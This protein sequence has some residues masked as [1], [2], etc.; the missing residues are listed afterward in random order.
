MKAATTN[1][2]MAFKTRREEELEAAEGGGDDSVDAGAGL[3]RGAVQRMQDMEARAAQ[4]K[5]MLARGKLPKAV[6]E[7]PEPEKSPSRN[8]PHS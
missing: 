4:M 1:T 8:Q 7:V 5:A 6:R 3:E 2:G